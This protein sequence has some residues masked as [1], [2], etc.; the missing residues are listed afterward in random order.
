MQGPGAFDF[1]V[2]FYSK[3]ESGEPLCLELVIENQP[4]FGFALNGDEIEKN[5]L[6]G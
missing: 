2:L 6:S 1:P 4:T 3:L 5:L